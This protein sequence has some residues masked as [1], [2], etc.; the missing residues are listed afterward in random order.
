MR[1]TKALGA[2]GALIVAALVGGTLIGAT[3]A[4]DETDDATDATG[5]TDGAYCDTYL[6]TLA[7]ELGVTRDELTEAGQAAAN[8]TID[9]AVTDG[10]LSEDR[11]ETLRDRIAEY[12]GSG[13]GWF[14]KAHAFGRGFGAGLDRGIA[15]GFAGGDIF[16][17]AAEAFGV[18]SDDLIGDLRDAGSL[19]ALAEERG[20]SYDDVKASVLAAV[21]ADLD[22]AVAE[23]L[24]QERADAVVERLTEWLDDGGVLRPGPG[25]GPGRGHLHGPW[26][27]SDSESDADDED[28]AKA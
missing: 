5:T 22:A 7:A 24:S 3:L 14:G 27:D 10:N 1:L 21:Q 9:R 13:C 28:A 8:A 20:V 4:A 11:A 26:H 16:E 18:A 15:R 6:D 19:Q 25:F 12:D 17:A 2:A 23:G